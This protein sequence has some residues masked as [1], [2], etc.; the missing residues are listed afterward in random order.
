MLKCKLL[1]LESECLIS[2]D[3][4][5]A[6]GHADVKA[7]NNTNCRDPLAYHSFPRDKVCS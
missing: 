7:R 2:E 5:S 6:G 4:T 1:S 3:K